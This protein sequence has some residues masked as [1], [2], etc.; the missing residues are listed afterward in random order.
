MVNLWSCGLGGRLTIDEYVAV[1]CVLDTE[2]VGSQIPTNLIQN[3]GFKAI[4][5]ALGRIVGLA[6]LHQDSKP[7]MFYMVECMCP[8]LYDWSI[9]LLR[10][11]K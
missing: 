3:L 1:H 8:T 4:L 11:M 9:L 6:S 7:L 2:N 10:N 5:L